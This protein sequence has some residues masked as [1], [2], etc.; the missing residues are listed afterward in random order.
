VG[1]F[2][3]LASAFL[4]GAAIVVRFRG[5]S[6][7]VR[8]QIKWLAFVAVGFLAELVLTIVLTAL[9]GD[10]SDIGDSIGNIMFWVWTATLL[11]GIPVAC[12]IAILKYRLY[13]LDIVV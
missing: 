6:L 8:Q 2:A 11:I 1:A 12:G 5:A 9:F 13:D 3:M 4:A 7:E 10:R